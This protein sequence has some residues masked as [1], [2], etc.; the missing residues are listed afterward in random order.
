MSLSSVLTLINDVDTKC[1][2]TS[3][4][5]VFRME[6]LAKTEARGDGSYDGNQRIVYSHLPNRV[7]A[8]QFVVERGV[9]QRKGEEKPPVFLDVRFISLIKL[10]FTH[11]DTI[12]RAN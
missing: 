7:A 3:G 11:K 5:G 1:D 6:R 9:H 10:K 4:K 12:K 8:K 2:E